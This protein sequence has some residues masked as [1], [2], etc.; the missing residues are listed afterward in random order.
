[1]A[2]ERRMPTTRAPTNAPRMLPRPPMTTTAKASTISSMP[3]SL[4]GGA[5]REDAHEDAANDD[6][7]RLGHLAVVGRGADDS[8]EGGAGQEPADAERDGEARRHDDEVV[9]GHR[10]TEDP[11]LSVHEIESGGGARGRAPRHADHVLHHEHEGER[12]QELKALVTLVDEAQEPSLDHRAHQAHRDS[13]DDE[14][15]EEQQWR[16]ARPDES[17]H[18][19][20]S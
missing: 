5:E 10:R 17:A 18:R 8:P 2:T 7:E 16:S 15:R 11:R 14:R 12:E 13:R 3:I 20:N 9:D 4:G 6:A 19:G 1:M